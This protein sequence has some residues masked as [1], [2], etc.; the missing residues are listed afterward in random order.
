M[1]NG[2]DPATRLEVRRRLS[3]PLVA[4]PEHWLH[5]QRALLSK[6]AKVAKAINFLLSPGHRPGFTLFLND[7]R[8]C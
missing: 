7:G 1:A 3:A 5:S 6:H 4:D 2:Q 8:V